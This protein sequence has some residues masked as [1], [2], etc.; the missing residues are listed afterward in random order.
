M[1]NKI[2][3]LYCI[4]LLFQQA[5]FKLHKHEQLNNKNGITVILLIRTE[6]QCN[7]MYI[8]YEKCHNGKAH[9]GHIDSYL[10]ISPCTNSWE[11]MEPRLII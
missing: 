7:L 4:I 5:N 1:L 8:L 2:F 6:L 10:S 3:V 11:S 9:N